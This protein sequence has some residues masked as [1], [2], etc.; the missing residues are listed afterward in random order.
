MTKRVKKK[1]SGGG[2]DEAFIR[3]KAAESGHSPATLRKV[4]KRGRAAYLSSGSKSASM[5]AWSRGRVNSFVRGSKKHDTDLR[6]GGKSNG[7][8]KT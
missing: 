5:A 4:L 2:S 3:K 1:S 6:R 7:S 8:K